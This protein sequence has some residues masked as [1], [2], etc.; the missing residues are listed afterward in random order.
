MDETVS[1]LLTRSIYQPNQKTVDGAVRRELP[2]LSIYLLTF[3]GCLHALMLTL[4][5][6]LIRN[7][8][9]LKCRSIFIVIEYVLR[10][11][12]V[13]ILAFTIED[14]NVFPCIRITNP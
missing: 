9:N 13:Q 4:S 2:L 7:L 1:N 14:I 12:T 3:I 10:F 11:P 6:K 5:R 8:I